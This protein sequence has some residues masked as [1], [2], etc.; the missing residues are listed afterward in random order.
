MLSVLYLSPTTVHI[1]IQ[2]IETCYRK[3]PTECGQ[4]TRFDDDDAGSWK[5]EGRNHNS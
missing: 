3:S 5:D 1:Q 4:E 2:R